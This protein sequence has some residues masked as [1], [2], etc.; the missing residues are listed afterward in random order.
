MFSSPKLRLRVFWHLTLVDLY[1]DRNA[2]TA[3][4]EGFRKTATTMMMVLTVVTVALGLIVILC[5]KT[6]YQISDFIQNNR[7]LKI[8]NQESGFCGLCWRHADTQGANQQ[9]N[10]IAHDGDSVPNGPRLISGAIRVF[11]AISLSTTG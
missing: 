8:K 5:D 6:E 4:D 10:V 7:D 1:F 3:V 9:Q 2:E 11:G